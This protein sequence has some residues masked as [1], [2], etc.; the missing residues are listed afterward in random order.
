MHLLNERPKTFE[1]NS[2]SSH[3]LVVGHEKQL[4]D[5][6][7]S[8]LAKYAHAGVIEA[9]PGE[10]GWGPEMRGTT[11]EDRLSYLYTAEQYMPDYDLATLSAE[12]YEWTGCELRVRS[13]NR[14]S[15]QGYI[16]HQSNDLPHQEL[17]TPE[18]RFRFLFSNDSYIA[19]D[20]D[21]H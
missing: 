3:T 7:A 18:E 9:E 11:F 20:H 12:I 13:T 10:F 1:T 5:D 17:N 19:V 2:S 21:N 8:V 4:P 14:Y 6:A 15:M 16:D